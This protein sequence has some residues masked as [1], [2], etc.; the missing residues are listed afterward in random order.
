MK[1]QLFADII[2]ITMNIYTIQ[3]ITGKEDTFLKLWEKLNDRHN[4]NVYWPRRELMIRRHGH[5]RKQLV[6]VFPGYLFV[7]AQE[8]DPDIFQEFRHIH[9]FNRF[10]K[11][12]NNICPLPED[13]QRVIIQLTNKG[14]I[15]KQSKVIFNE[16]DRIVVVEGPMMGFEGKI[17]KVDKRR[18][19]AK[20]QLSLYHKAH[21]VD[22]GFE[23]LEP[24]DEVSNV[25]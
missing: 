25:G 19:R 11:S 1:I 24:A 9:Y 21:P 4:L 3:V 17:I 14:K 18:K 16:Q 20:V 12:N 13:E 2:L 10:L 5:T 23:V 7:E 22:F 8:I 15:I 6:P